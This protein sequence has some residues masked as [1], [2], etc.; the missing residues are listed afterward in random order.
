MRITNFLRYGPLALA[1]LLTGCNR[2]EEIAKWPEKG[3]YYDPAKPIAI[4]SMTPDWGRINQSFV[5]TGN[6][7]LDLEKI[8]V[9]FADREA[10]LVNSDGRDL[11]GLVPK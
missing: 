10:V 3:N 8:K 9:Y 4:E 6:F 1:L 7:P 11:Y 2:E 5:I